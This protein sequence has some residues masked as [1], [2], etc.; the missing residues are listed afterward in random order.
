MLSQ[1]STPR[2]VLPVR[3]P[4]VRAVCVQ[5][6]P[7]YVGVCRAFLAGEH[8]V[9]HQVAVING[10]YNYKGRGLFLL[11]RPYLILLACFPWPHGTIKQIATVLHAA[12]LPYTVQ[13]NGGDYRIMKPNG[14]TLIG[15]L[16]KKSLTFDL[17][18]QELVH[19]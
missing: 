6:L 17:T 10:V 14:K 7:Y 12:N 11:N 16:R 8:V 9:F 19:K 5:P 15:N 4:S 2:H 3:K 1:I 18:T 13:R